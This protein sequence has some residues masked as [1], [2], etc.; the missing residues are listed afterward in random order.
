MPWDPYDNRFQFK[1]V[2]SKKKK[3]GNT[4]QSSHN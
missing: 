2:A 1:D 4:S 3:K